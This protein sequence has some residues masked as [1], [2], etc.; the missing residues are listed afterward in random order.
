MLT[1]GRRF[2]SSRLCKTRSEILFCK[3]NDDMNIETQITSELW[4][5][6]ASSYLAGNYTHAISDAMALITDTLRDKSGLDGDG[7]K[8]ASKALW[9]DKDKKDKPPLIRINRLQT[10]TEQDTQKGLMLVLQGMYALIRNTRAH[11]RMDDTKE[12]ADKIILFIDFLL[13]LL[14]T[15]QQ[16]FTIQ[17]FLD[18]VT[19]KYFV[20]NAEYMKEL[21]DTIPIR[22]LGDTLIAIY[23]AKN[24]PQAENFVTAIR[25]IIARAG[26]DHISDFLAVVSEELMKVDKL[27]E[28]A[29]IIKILP[30]NLWPRLD[31]MARLR[32]ENMFIQEL[33]DARYI[34]V[35]KETNSPAS[36]WITSIMKYSALRLDLLSTIVKKLS[37]DDFNQHNF[38][39]NYL[40]SDLSYLS[41]TDVEIA[42]CVKAFARSI[43]SGNA[44]VKDAV[45]KHLLYAG[46]IEW[47]RRFVKELQ[48]LTDT[49]KPEVLLPENG[50]S[51]PKTIPFLG[52]FVAAESPASP[53]SSGD[54]IPF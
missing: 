26:D 53:P 9:F 39:A 48:D 4:A 25:A 34:P 12:T 35:Q 18:T 41:K 19:E 37:H 1:G 38:V 27:S 13:S 42:Y 17:D 11:E 43:R 49:E 52:R 36:T 22:K 29:L 40:M 7:D 51:S 28:T 23:R 20:N 10:Q 16:S 32:A 2:K 45:I 5:S 8:L 31:K 6:I 33:S 46:S 44:F 30:D 50:P 21:V 3:D 15:S 47:T 24:W 14:G 54:D